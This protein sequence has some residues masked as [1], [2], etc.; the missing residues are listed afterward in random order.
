MLP[1]DSAAIGVMVEYR[2]LARGAGRAQA[3]L[4]RGSG[5]SAESIA[6]LACWC[7]VPGYAKRNPAAGRVAQRRSSMAGSRMPAHACG[8]AESTGGNTGEQ[9]SSAALRWGRM[10]LAVL[11]SCL[12]AGVASR[13]EDAGLRDSSADQ[14]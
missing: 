2:W 8:D 6:R 14:G 4:R 1:D 11:R 3:P 10:R 12:C 7:L 9:G 13:A 5:Q